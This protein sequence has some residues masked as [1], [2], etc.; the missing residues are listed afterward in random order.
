VAPDDPKV[1]EAAAR[2][3]D[4]MDRTKADPYT[5]A[6]LA[7]IADAG[8]SRLTARA[9]SVTADDT[10]TTGCPFAPRCPDVLDICHTEDPSAR[11]IDDRR[12]RCH[13]YPEGGSTPG[14]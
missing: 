8:D 7:S 6:L 1:K 5:R 14:S 11:V 9:P 2:L 10:A 4:T 13:L 12:V 3:L